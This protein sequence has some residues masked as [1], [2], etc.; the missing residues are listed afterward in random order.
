MKLAPVLVTKIYGP[1]YNRGMRGLIK[2]IWR[3]PVGSN[4]I[5][6]GIASA[7][8]AVATWLW[9]ASNF[10]TNRVVAWTGMQASV[11]RLFAWFIA[12][13]TV[14]RGAIIDLILVGLAGYLLYFR[15]RNRRAEPEEDPIFAGVLK[16]AKLT[17]AQ[18]SLLALLYRNGDTGSD[19]AYAASVNGDGYEA[20]AEAAQQLAVEH[21]IVV[22]QEGVPKRDRAWLTR[23]GHMYCL[24]FA[25]D[26]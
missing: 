7:L 18:R 2:R 20:T 21:L 22:M 26:L 23:R 8:L 16:P 14:L 11:S 6:G 1:A 19:L 12:P 9:S 17:G 24:K 4:L 3:D 15:Q 25:L 10:S 5:A 13:V